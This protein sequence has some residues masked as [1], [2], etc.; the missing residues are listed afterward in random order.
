M[1]ES[2][3]DDPRPSSRKCLP[4]PKSRPAVSIDTFGRE[5]TC[6]KTAS[7]K[8]EWCPPRLGKNFRT[9][10]MSLRGRR[11]SGPPVRGDKPPKQSN[12]QAVNSASS[13][14]SF[15]SLRACRSPVRQTGTL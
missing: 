2:R 11:A 15:R 9:G 6:W 14:A 10:R 7:A 8:V 1:H 3:P 12:C 5:P 4:G 13:S